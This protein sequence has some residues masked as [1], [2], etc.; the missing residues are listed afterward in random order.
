MIRTPLTFHAPSS[1]ADAAQILAEHAE[2]AAVLGGGTLLVPMMSRGERHCEHL[3][4]LAGLGLDAITPDDEGVRIGARVTYATAIDSEL[5]GEHA[6]L[7]A[8]VSQGIT[9][10]GQLRNQATIGGSAC[11][12]N[13]S[14]DMPAVLVALNARM[15]I[16]GVDGERR[17]PAA[18][19]FRGPFD[20]ALRRGELLTG[21]LIPRGAGPFGYYKLKHCEGSWPI[22]TA[23][24]TTDPD[25][26]RYVTLGGVAST[27]LRLKANEPERLAEQVDT[28]LTDPWSDVLAPGSYRRQVAATIARRALSA[29]DAGE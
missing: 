4:D 19:F 5:I 3:V 25:G 29:L 13:P 24:A 7:V 22:A 14:S 8:R 26:I 23:A 15:L 16:F 21:M 12:A 10:G 6:A 28:A 9:G 1:L 20:N 27:P 11:W 2:A 17:L 18:E